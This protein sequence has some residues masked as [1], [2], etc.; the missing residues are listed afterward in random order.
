MRQLRATIRAAAPDAD[1][2]ITYKM[3]GFKAGQAVPGLV[4]R[5]VQGALQPVPVERRDHRRAR[6]RGDAARQGS[7]DAPVPGRGA[8]AAR[9]HPADRRD[10]GARGR[11]GR[12]RLD[13]MPVRSVATADADRRRA[14]RDPGAD[15]RR[16]RRLHRRRHDARPRGAALHR[17]RSMGPLA[18]HASVV[19][20]ALE[21]DGTRLR[22][23]Y[24]ESVAVAPAL[25]RRGLG[26]QV[27]AAAPRT[28]ATRTS[29]VPWGP[30]SSRSTSRWAGN[31]GPGR[32]FVRE[33]DGTLRHT[34]DEDP[35][36]MV[37]RTGPSAD[38]PL[39]GT[40]HLRV[41][42]RRRLV[43]PGGARPGGSCRRRGR[44]R[45]ARRAR[46]RPGSGRRGRRAS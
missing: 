31:A 22:A 24:V 39:T 6:R 9:P 12:G 34:A 46:S 5:R 14:A 33:R 37:L 21:L 8:A 36:L 32:S 20:R 7:R 18:A 42:R 41:A 13:L 1:E 27:M 26:T 23:G 2:V 10:P 19:E 11:R 16:L 43:T 25:Q 17:S 28:S 40:P 44:S 45:R 3:P 29:S 38:A 35:W 30:A 15:G 4:L